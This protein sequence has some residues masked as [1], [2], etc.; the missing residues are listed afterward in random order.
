MG[1]SKKENKKIFSNEPMICS[2]TCPHCGVTITEEVYISEGST[3]LFC[4]CGFNLIVTPI[5][6]YIDKDEFVFGV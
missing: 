4:D 3:V 2:F 6:D 5:S 1:I